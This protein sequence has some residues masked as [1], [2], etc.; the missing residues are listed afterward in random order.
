MSF[1]ED[2][3]RTFSVPN[4]TRTL[5]QAAPIAG[6]AV[7]SLW[8]PAGAGIGL[9]AGTAL[10]QRQGQEEANEA[11]T[12]QS[13]AQM[14][15]QERM[16]STAH[17]RQVADLRAAGLNPILSSNAG[18]SSPAGAA[19]NVKSTTEAAGATAAQ[20][21]EMAMQYENLKTQNLLLK[22]QVGKTAM[23]T[24]KIGIDADVAKKDL[25]ES[26]LTTG[27]WNW[28]KKQW[29]EAQSWNSESV[30][31]SKKDFFDGKWTERPVNNK[32]LKNP[33]L[34]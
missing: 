27:I 31:K 24:R 8:G 21:A 9:A 26:E 20:T 19:A 3:G 17:Q 13:Q 32:A 23:E 7:G 5:Q 16:S 12:A 14:E 2:L 18:A 33:Q 6:A 10:S 34:Y 1:A 28:V 25:P 29:K 11:N 30:R 15:F 4:I 22:A